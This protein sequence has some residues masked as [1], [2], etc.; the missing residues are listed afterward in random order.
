[1]WQH[2][3]PQG[4]PR[5]ACDR[6]KRQSPPQPPGMVARQ[7][8]GWGWLGYSKDLDKLVISTTANQDPL[9]TQVRPPPPFCLH[10]SIARYRNSHLA[11]SF[12]SWGWGGGRRQGLTPLLGIDVWE[13]AYYLQ[14][15]NKRPDYLKVRPPLCLRTNLSSAGNAGRIAADMICRNPALDSPGPHLT[16]LRGLCE[17]RRKF[18]RSLTGRTSGSGLPMPRHEV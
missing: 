17:F 15:K 4:T 9:I 13:H 12:A 8:S 11:Y 10:C 6:H 14:Y 1:M 16:S 3:G 7:G 5:A 2:P 18:G